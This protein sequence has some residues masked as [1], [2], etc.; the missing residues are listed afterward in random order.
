MSYRLKPL[1]VDI[2]KWTGKQLDLSTAP[3]WVNLR[4][5]AIL[6]VPM[7]EL[8]CLM[9]RGNETLKTN[10]FEPGEYIL[11]MPDGKVF[12]MTEDDMAERIDV[13]EDAPSPAPTPSPIPVA[14][15]LPPQPYEPQGAEPHDG[16]LCI[17]YFAT[18]KENFGKPYWMPIDQW[19]ELDPQV[20]PLGTRLH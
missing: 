5:I 2:F 17:K 3:A 4:F 9:I 6:P 12:G 18:G 8:W 19:N 11:R 20:V 7:T 14:T 1:P 15:A 10:L 13:I 16:V